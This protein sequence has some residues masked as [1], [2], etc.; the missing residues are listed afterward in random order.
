L[1][2]LA[3]ASYTVTPSLKL[4][5][6]YGAY[7]GSTET[8]TTT[9]PITMGS[10]TIG[11]LEERGEVKLTRTVSFTPSDQLSTSI[12][13]GALG[14]QRAGDSRINAALL[15]QPIPF[16]SPGPANVWGG[17]GGMGL[18]WQTRNVTLFSAGEYFG[19]SDNSTLVSGRAGLR[20]SF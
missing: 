1:G 9:A 18:E 3:D 12:Y 14:T 15:G 10:R 13:G 7:D 5:Y 20:V 16:A 17:F 4:R 8:G 6:L 19:F 11:T 2:K